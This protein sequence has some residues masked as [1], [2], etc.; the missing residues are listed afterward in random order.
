MGQVPTHRYLLIG[1]GALARHIHFYLQTTLPASC[2]LDRWNRR[3]FSLDDLEQK[4][5]QAFY[6]LLAISDGALE[7]FFKTHRSQAPQAQW[8]HFSGASQIEGLISTHPLMSFGP[9]LYSLDH[10]KKIHFVLTGT[11]D[12]K[13]LFPFWSNSFSVLPAEKKALYHSLCVL[14]G[15]LPVLLWQKMSEG[16]KD[17]G[18]SSEAGDFY[19]QTVLKNYLQHR[20]K[21]LTGPLARKDLVTIQKNLASLE[22]DSYQKIYSAFVEAQNINPREL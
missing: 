15:T 8:I 13:T 6:V 14:G 5:S 2:H 11:S 12:L 19:L 4:L 18:L 21:A 17:L 16:F 3:E 1:S 9:E 7:D 22:K 10:Y 20:E